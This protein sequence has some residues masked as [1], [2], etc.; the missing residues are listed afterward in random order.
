MILLYKNSSIADYN[1]L[2][3][4]LLQRQEIDNHVISS[5]NYGSKRIAVRVLSQL[6]LCMECDTIMDSSNSSTDN[7][8]CSCCSNGCTCMGSNDC[9]CNSFC[10]CSCTVLK[11]S[12]NGGVCTCIGG[13]ASS[14]EG[15]ICAIHH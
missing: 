13:V 11:S 3:K 2:A 9:G 8:T 4:K 10:V 6:S 12:N 15:R 14:S 5:K 1:I 7:N